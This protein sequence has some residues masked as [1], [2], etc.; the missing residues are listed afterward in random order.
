MPGLARCAPALRSLLLPHSTLPFLRRLSHTLQSSAAGAAATGAR[1][2]N[3]H[4]SATVAKMRNIGITAHIDAGKTTVSRAALFLSAEYDWC[5]QVS[6]R[7]L[8]YSGRSSTLGEVHHGDTVMDFMKVLHLPFLPPTQPFPYLWRSSF[9]LLQSPL[10]TL[11]C[12]SWKERG[13]SQSA[14]PPS[15]SR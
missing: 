3:G 8:F 11:A 14:A 7:L 5:M 10:T 1:S 2:D 9:S 12:C 4:A 13:A 6:E 15:V